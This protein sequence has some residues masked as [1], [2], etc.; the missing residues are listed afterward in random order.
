MLVD[1]TRT[2][3]PYLVFLNKP[4]VLFYKLFVPKVFEYAASTKPEFAESTMIMLGPY[5]KLLVLNAI[6]IF[7]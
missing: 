6:H 7:F 4:L 1:K 2:E 5:F 3:K